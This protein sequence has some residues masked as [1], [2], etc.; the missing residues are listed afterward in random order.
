MQK[1]ENFVHPILGNYSISLHIKTTPQNI[2]FNGVIKKD[3]HV[4]LSQQLRALIHNSAHYDVR[5]K[6]ILL[7]SKTMPMTNEVR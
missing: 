1:T 4:L 2:S 7:P 5:P 6:L 3:V